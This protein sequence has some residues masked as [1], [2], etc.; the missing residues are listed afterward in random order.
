MCAGLGGR[1]WYISHRVLCPTTKTWNSLRKQFHQL[2]A[3]PIDGFF[4]SFIFSAGNGVSAGLDAGGAGLADNAQKS[5]EPVPL[6]LPDYPARVL[7]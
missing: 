2:R 3:G 7:H 4:R 5:P 1:Y 6:T